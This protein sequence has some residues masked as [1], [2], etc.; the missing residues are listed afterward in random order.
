MEVLKTDK[1]A[2]S[3]DA[4]WTPASLGEALESASHLP[5]QSSSRFRSKPIWSISNGFRVFGWTHAYTLPYA[6]DLLDRVDHKDGDQKRGDQKD[7]T[8]R[9][10]GRCHVARVIVSATDGLW[11]ALLPVGDSSPGPGDRAFRSP[12]ARCVLALDHPVSRRPRRARLHRRRSRSGCAAAA[13]RVPWCAAPPEDPPAGNDDHRQ[14]GRRQPGRTGR[15]L[16]GGE[17]VRT[18]ARAV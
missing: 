13:H 16:S 3:F 5:K 17:E 9:R 18:C 15:P 14:S 12:P 8:S 1:L 2:K 11:R 10:A 6:L 7:R 4:A